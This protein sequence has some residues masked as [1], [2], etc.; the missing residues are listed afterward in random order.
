MRFFTDF[1]EFGDV[2]TDEDGSNA[3]DIII[4]P[5]DMYETL[6]EHFA[7]VSPPIKALILSTYVKMMKIFPICSRKLKMVSLCERKKT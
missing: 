3:D 4:A 6:A 5:S 7:R 2:L 1:S